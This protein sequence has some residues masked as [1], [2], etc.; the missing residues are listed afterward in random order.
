[1]YSVYWL[2]KPKGSSG[3]FPVAWHLRII[4]ISGASVNSCACKCMHTWMYRIIAYEPLYFHILFN[5]DNVFQLYQLG[6]QAFKASPYEIFVFFLK[7]WGY[8]E[9]YLMQ[10]DKLCQYLIKIK[11]SGIH[12]SLPCK[13]IHTNWICT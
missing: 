3:L 11:I 5:N 8:L 12:M 7:K 6:L 9:T 10:V 2:I 4:Y 13:L 1:M